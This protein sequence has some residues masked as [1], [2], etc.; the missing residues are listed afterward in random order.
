MWIN[1]E[2]TGNQILPQKINPRNTYLSI[3]PCKVL[4]VL[5]KLDKRGAQKPGPENKGSDDYSQN[6]AS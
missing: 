3:L 6:L 1:K 2:T 5:P 4:W